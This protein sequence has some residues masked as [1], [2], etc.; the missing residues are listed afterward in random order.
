MGFGTWNMR[1][2]I[3]NNDRSR[4]TVLE[5]KTVIAEFEWLG[6]NLDPAYIEELRVAEYKEL[7]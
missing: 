3:I 7:A 5:N 4:I 2:V 6:G 1:L